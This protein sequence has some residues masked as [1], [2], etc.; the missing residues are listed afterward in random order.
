M[1]TNWKEVNFD[2]NCA[3]AFLVTLEE[4]SL[5]A[6]AKALNV[7]QPTISRQ[8]AALEKEL[9][10]LLFERVGKSLTP[11]SSALSLATHV[12]NMGNAAT[13]LSLGASGYSQKIDGKVCISC[14]ELTAVFIL[15]EIIKELRRKY[16]TIQIELLSSNDA[17]DLRGREADIAIRAFR[18]TEPEL[19]ARKLFDLHA[20]LY[21]TPEYLDSIGR[22]QNFEQLTDASFIGFLNDNDEYIEELNKR[23]VK[24]TNL[25]F[26]VLSNNHTSHWNMVK[27]GLGIGVVPVEMG[28]ADPAV[29]RVIPNSIIFEGEFWLVS[30]SELRTSK[31]VKS[32]FD[33]LVEKLCS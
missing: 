19:I 32:V 30:H 1:S 28:D 6:A 11:T 22:P 24:V 9:G 18:P 16:P 10:V 5:S 13:R 33:F 17:S 21:A 29:E 2:W 27:L 23:K 8:V 15:P 31:R 7:T 4:G 25:N 14:T 3:R 12:Q 20:S 26:P